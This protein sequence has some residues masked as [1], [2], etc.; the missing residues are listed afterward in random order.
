MRRCIITKNSL[1]GLRGRTGGGGGSSGGG[2]QCKSSHLTYRS[3]HSMLFWLIVI[4][5]LS[6]C[7]KTILGKSIK[8]SIVSVNHNH[9]QGVTSNPLKH[10]FS[11]YPIGSG[12][13][14]IIF[15]LN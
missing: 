9:S 12:A 4:I 6:N 14:K 2:R 5:I 3:T 1:I 13:I 11:K 10:T 8:G 7:D 15:G